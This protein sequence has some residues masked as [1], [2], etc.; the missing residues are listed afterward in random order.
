[1]LQEWCS[2]RCLCLQLVVPQ[3]WVVIGLPMQ[4]V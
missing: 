1:L 4:V 3:Y 2:S